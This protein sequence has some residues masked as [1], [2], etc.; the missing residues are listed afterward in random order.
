[1]GRGAW[2][3]ARSAFEHSLRADESP[4][5]MFGLAV[6]LWWLGEV[7][8]PVRHL[9][10]AYAAFR[11]RSDPAQA[12]GAALE[13]CFL[14][15]ENLG[16]HAAAC[17]MMQSCDRCADFQ[18]AAQWV[19][20]MDRFIERYGCPYLNATCRAH[21]G[22]V[23]FA[24]GDWEEA[25]K[26]LLA[27]VAMSGEAMPA[28]RG[29]AVAGLAELRLAQGR[30]EE[31]E[32]LL[33]GFEDH[34]AAVPVRAMI[35]LLRGR[36]AVAVA[37][38]RR[39]L[40]AIGGEDRLEGAELVELLGEAEI[41]QGQAEA[42]ADRGRKLGEL[43]NT[44]GSRVMHARGERLLG[45]ALA[46]GS[47]ARH[48]L[49]AAVSTFVSLEMPLEAARTRLLLARALREPDP[50][51]AEAEARAALVAFENLG[52][53]GDART[54]AALLREIETRTREQTNGV[55]G[56]SQ[57]EAEVLRLVAH[58]MSNK[59]IADRL[60]LSKH[61]VHRHVSSILTKLDLPSR[62]A[63]AAFAVRHGLL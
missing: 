63:A 6:A 31:A 11:R 48:H 2:E 8:E 59:E 24:A 23:M 55:S 53:N 50:E 38:L 39:R 43:G 9:E 51:V 14:Y 56:L 34:E 22:R 15:H 46:P 47:D 25:E 42:A 20:A 13:L 7:R 54:A 32:R 17:R 37:T 41:G 18:R 12:A 3:E 49:D 4:E 28:L 58:G 19:R 35:H 61:T 1:M 60:T 45:R 16:N 36:L 44:L 5:A 30:V 52:A 33:A 27:G 26:E 29:E 57:R 62:T 40:G 21:Y 10:Q